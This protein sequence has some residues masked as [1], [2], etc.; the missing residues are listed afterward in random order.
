MVMDAPC[1]ASEAMLSRSGTGVRPAMR[2]RITDWLTPGRVYSASAA[3][4]APQKPE[5]PG[6]TAYCRPYSSSASI[7][8]RMAP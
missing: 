8:S 7:C 6:V 2:V 5:T 1:A 4:A 3:A